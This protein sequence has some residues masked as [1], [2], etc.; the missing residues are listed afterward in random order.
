MHSKGLGA[1]N[2]EMNTK[3]N[4]SSFMKLIFFGR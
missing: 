1:K 4:L 3:E 2:T